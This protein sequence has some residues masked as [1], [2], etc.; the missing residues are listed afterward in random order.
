MFIISQDKCTIIP[1]EKCMITINCT[2]IVAYSKDFFGDGM[3]IGSY[4]SRE[5]AKAI[6]EDIRYELDIK[7]SEVYA[8]PSE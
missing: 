4:S 6:L 3:I 1:L 7:E 8:L 2:S 5:R